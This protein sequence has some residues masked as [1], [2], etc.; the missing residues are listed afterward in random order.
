MSSFEQ[1]PHYSTFKRKARSIPCLPI[2]FLVG[3][4]GSGLP[5]WIF[6]AP[7]TIACR[8]TRGKVV[9]STRTNTFSFTTKIEPR[10]DTQRAV[11]LPQIWPSQNGLVRQ[12]LFHFNLWGKPEIRDGLEKQIIAVGSRELENSSKCYNFLNYSFLQSAKNGRN[13][14]FFNF[15]EKFR[16]KSTQLNIY[17]FRFIIHCQFLKLTTRWR[18]FFCKFCKWLPQKK[19]RPSRPWWR[20]SSSISWR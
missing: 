11:N 15:S 9:Y 16:K 13:S 7:L 2:F 8:T 18:H 3:S 4:R 14:K 6:R 19:S 12:K 5:H 1:P 20:H 10:R 17:V